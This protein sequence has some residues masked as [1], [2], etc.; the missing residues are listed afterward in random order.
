[1]P[2]HGLDQRFATPQSLRTY[3]RHP[4]PTRVCPGGWHASE[5]A[6]EDYAGTDT[7]VER[8]TLVSVCLQSVRTRTHARA[9][10][11][12]HVHAR[13]THM[14]ARMHHTRAIWFN[15]KRALGC[16]GLDGVWHALAHK[17]V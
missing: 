13:A 1:M 17:A 2:L 11:R 15:A 4:E 5:H 10:V 16:A 9:R 7:A 6:M 14:R 12:T 3:E 8:P